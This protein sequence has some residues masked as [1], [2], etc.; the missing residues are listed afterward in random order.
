MSPFRHHESAHPESRFAYQSFS[1]LAMTSLCL[2]AHAAHCTLNLMPHSADGLLQLVSNSG[3]LE[4]SL[5]V[6]HPLMVR[7]SR[8]GSSTVMARP[9]STIFPPSGL[10]SGR[11]WRIV[12]VWAS[13]ARLASVHVRLYTVLAGAG[14]YLLGRL[15]TR[16]ELGWLDRG[17]R[18]C[19]FPISGSSTA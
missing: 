15:W 10:L 9:S 6:D 7:V 12:W 13:S 11:F 2:V 1:S 18:L 17:R 5:R 14:M 19:L 8:P 3:A 4:H 16:S